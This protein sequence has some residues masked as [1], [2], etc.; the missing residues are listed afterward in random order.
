MF[1]STGGWSE[2]KVW[3]GGTVLNSSATGWDNWLAGT[4][5]EIGWNVWREWSPG[6]YSGFKAS[7]CIKCP[8]G[9]IWNSNKWTSWSICPAGT[10]SSSDSTTCIEWPAGTYSSSSGSSS[11][12]NCPTN[13]YSDSNA[14]SWK[15]WGIGFYS[16]PGDPTWHTIWGDGIRAGSEKWDD[17]NTTPYDGCSNLW[18]IETGYACIG[19]TFVYRDV[20]HIVWGDGIIV[21]PENWDDWNGYSGDGWSS[22]CQT[23]PNYICVDDPDWYHQ[24]QRW[25]L[26]WGNGFIDSENEQWDDGNHYSFD[27]WNINWQL[28]V[29]YVCTGGS[30]TTSTIWLENKFMP[31]AKIQVLP[32]NNLIIKFNDTITNISPTKD[33]LYIVIYGPQTS[34]EFTWTASFQDSS[35]LLV[36]MDISSEITGQ[37]ESIYVEFPFTNSFLSIYSHRPANPDAVLNGLLYTKLNSNSSEILGQTTLYIFLLSVLISILSSFG[38]NSMEMMWIFTNYLQLIY[39]IS[40]VNV[41]FPDIINIYFPYI[42]IWNANNPILS[43][44]SYLAIPKDKFVRGDVSDSIGSKAFYVSASDKLPVLIPVVILFW[45]A[46]LTDIWKKCDQIWCLKYVYRLIDHLKYNFFLR[47]WIELELELAFT[48]IVNIFFVSNIL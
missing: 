19:G 4:Y 15:S 40:A 38:G 29:G 37:G 30:S 8:G 20:C 6:Y 47:M 16:S 28:E 31:S 9:S 3:T 14:T 46:K 2:W 43:E 33:D 48:A 35:T 23:E 24:I 34:Y 10:S 21:S 45:I 1:W 17:R 18:T 42:Q 26:K 11:C 22:T 7:S 32:S 25:I 13:Y 39:Y 27:G 44:I 41:N 12:T 36:N 5:S